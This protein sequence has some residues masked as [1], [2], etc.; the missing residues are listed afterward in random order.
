MELSAQTE[1]KKLE[2]QAEAEQQKLS[3][4]TKLEVQKIKILQETEEEKFRIES[5]LRNKQS[6]KR[7]IAEET[8]IDR[9]K[10]EKEAATRVTAAKAE[11]TARL[12]LAKA[13]AEETRATVA[14]V[15][16]MH[17][18]MHAYDALGHLGG[19]G[20]TIM[21][22]DWS[23]T[24]QFLF[25]RTPAFQQIWGTPWGMG[26]SPMTPPPPAAHAPSAQN[27]GAAAPHDGKLS[28]NTGH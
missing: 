5:E 19:T 11:A 22:G 26:A 23:R 15:T 25:P 6:E 8:Q 7:L 2:L 18:M 28:Q 1:Q 20:T 14:N 4:T 13:S 21:L 3:A 10:S 12:A 9:M 16:P 24:P 27:D 17:V